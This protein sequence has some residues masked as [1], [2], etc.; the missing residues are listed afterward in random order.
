[1][2][3]KLSTLNLSITHDVLYTSQLHT[4]TL[5]HCIE[6]SHRP[7][8]NYL[9]LRYCTIL[10]ILS[11]TPASFFRLCQFAAFCSLRCPHLPIVY[12]CLYLSAT[13]KATACTV[14]TCPLSAINGQ[15]PHLMNPSILFSL[16]ASFLVFFFPFCAFP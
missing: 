16:S 12:S 5:F 1:M 9:L 8:Y 11:R 2:P 3:A 10:Y 14:Y 6:C 4:V 7:I 15:Q 13:S